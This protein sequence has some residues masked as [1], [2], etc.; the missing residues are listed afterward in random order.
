[1]L[2]IALLTISDSRTLDDDPSGDL[3]EQRL[4]KAS[5]GLAERRLC[6]DDRYSEER[7]VEDGFAPRAD[8]AYLGG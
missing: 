6:P 5:H 3:L 8:M 2:A 4:L 7:S 1:V